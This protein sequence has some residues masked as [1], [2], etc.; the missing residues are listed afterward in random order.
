MTQLARKPREGDVAAEVAE[1][2]RRHD[3]AYR[4][5]E[6]DALAWHISRL[7]DAEVEP[8]DTQNLL[9]A[10]VRAKVITS[11]ESMRLLG[12]HLRGLSGS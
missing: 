1:L 7:S 9:V 10:L 11:Q 4:P 6:T 12:E 5:T 3:V 2:A 8:D